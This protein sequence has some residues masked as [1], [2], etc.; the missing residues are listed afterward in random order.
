MDEDLRIAPL[1]VRL[2]DYFQERADSVGMEL[3][4]IERDRRDT[5]LAERVYEEKKGDRVFVVSPHSKSNFDAFS[6]KTGPNNEVDLLQ[7][8]I[9]YDEINFSRL[10]VGYLAWLHQAVDAESVLTLLNA[11]EG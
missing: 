11:I 6:K 3:N 9:S 10:W 2:L 1:R 4:P 5:I 8:F 7:V